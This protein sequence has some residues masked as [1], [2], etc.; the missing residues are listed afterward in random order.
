MGSGHAADGCENLGEQGKVENSHIR[1]LLP[2]ATYSTSYTFD[3]VLNITPSKS[4][5][6]CADRKPER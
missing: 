1:L 2:F 3:Y 6:V 4:I 5:F